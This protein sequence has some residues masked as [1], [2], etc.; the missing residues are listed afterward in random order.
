VNPA[1]RHRVSGF[2]PIERYRHVR[3]VAM[4]DE[5]LESGLIVATVVGAPSVL[6]IVAWWH[7]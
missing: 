6:E 3:A 5:W 7:E 1:P 2:G 4:D